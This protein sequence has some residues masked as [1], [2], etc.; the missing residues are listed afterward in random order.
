MTEK[1]QSDRARLE[2]WRAANPER[3]RERNRIHCRN[4]RRNNPEK[5]RAANA[6]CEAR[7]KAAA[8]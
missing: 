6:R 5:H 2:K 7:R 3:V 8:L 1:Q 4:W